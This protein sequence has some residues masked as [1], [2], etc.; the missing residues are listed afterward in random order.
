[1]QAIV[2]GIIFQ[3][4]LPRLFINSPDRFCMKPACTLHKFSSTFK[5]HSNIGD[6]LFGT[7]CKHCSAKTDTSFCYHHYFKS[8]IQNTAPQEVLWRKLYSMQTHNK[9]SH[10]N[11]RCK[12]AYYIVLIYGAE[13]FRKSFQPV[14][15]E[16][17][18]LASSILHMD[19]HQQFKG[20]LL[21]TYTLDVAKKQVIFELPVLTQVNQ[22]PSKR[23]IVSIYN[24]LLNGLS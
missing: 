16:Q 10:R 4:W 6:W 20:N 24:G 15:M 22:P 1:M 17:A 12:R 2:L 11:L 3:T 13:L 21:L 8:E 7:I 18:L 19:K 5:R 9:A 23:E 14:C